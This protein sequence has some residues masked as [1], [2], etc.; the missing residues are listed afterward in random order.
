MTSPPQGVANFPS[1]PPVFEDNSPKVDLS[2]AVEYAGWW[3]RVWA[4]IIDS[5]VAYIPL[6]IAMVIAIS[7]SVA[8][9]EK[10]RAGSYYSTSRFGSTSSF[11]EQQLPGFSATGVVVL[12]IGYCVLLLVVVL[13]RGYFAGKTGK[14]LGRKVMGIKLIS[15]RTGLPIGGLKAFGRDI[16]H[17]LDNLSIGVGYLFPLWDKKKQTFADKVIDSVVIRDRY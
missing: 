16:L 11:T 1:M 2:A 9:F 14:S 12:L 7:D 13:N 10:K 6:V 5:V 8:A 17:T 4:F 15:L 3:R